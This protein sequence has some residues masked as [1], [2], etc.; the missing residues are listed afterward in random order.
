MIEYLNNKGSYKSRFCF[1]LSAS[2][3]R[4][5][6]WTQERQNYVRKKYVQYLPFIYRQ[7]QS[8]EWEMKAAYEVVM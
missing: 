2:L 7:Q 4:S 6:I 3:V 8:F 1:V 5:R